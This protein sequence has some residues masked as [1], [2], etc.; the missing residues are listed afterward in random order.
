MG[1]RCTLAKSGLVSGIAICVYRER[2]E[3]ELL[4]YDKVQSHNTI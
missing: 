4:V 3:G 1:S 2:R